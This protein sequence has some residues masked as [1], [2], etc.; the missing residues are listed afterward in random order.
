MVMVLLCI[1]VYV[2]MYQTELKY[3]N[4]ASS[5][6]VTFKGYIL[7]LNDATIVQNIIKTPF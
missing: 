2:L 7:I 3:P 5:I 6:L 1:S 4:K